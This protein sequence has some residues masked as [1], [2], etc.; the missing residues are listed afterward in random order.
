MSSID[1]V[2]VK[3][4]VVNKTINVPN[5]MY[6]LGP[7]SPTRFMFGA[8]GGA[9]SASGIE[10]DRAEFQKKEGGSE[11]VIRA[12]VMEEMLAK[13]RESGKF[14]LAEN[15]R[16]DVATLYISVIQYGFSIPNGFSSKV[17]PILRI[18]CELKNSVG[19]ILWSDTEGTTPLGSPVEPVDVETIQQNAAV[20]DAA[21]RA[22][23]NKVVKN[24]VDS[25]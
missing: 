4:V 19:R 10:E 13:M 3:A 2:L 16:Q 14:P 21:W 9:L 23:A 5:K 12:I 20:R 25:Y 15:A 24:I 6:Y 17:V 11:A 1:K 7:G 22:A 18:K 8:V